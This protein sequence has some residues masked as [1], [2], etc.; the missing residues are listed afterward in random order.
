MLGLYPCPVCGISCAGQTGTFC[1]G[2]QNE[3]DVRDA[4]IGVEAG[5][6]LGDACAG[7]NGGIA[8]E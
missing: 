2:I 6:R 3:G 5:I 7:E 4:G 1:V 8:D